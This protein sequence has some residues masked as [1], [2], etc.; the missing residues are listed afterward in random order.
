MTQLT[1]L[2]SFRT[3][4]NY[5]LLVRICENCIKK[6]YHKFFGSLLPIQ[7]FNVS[8]FLY[9]K[10]SSFSFVLVMAILATLNVFMWIKSK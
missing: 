4:T 2:K 10:E 1:V 3:E 5:Y 7:F 6:S 9:L 8:N